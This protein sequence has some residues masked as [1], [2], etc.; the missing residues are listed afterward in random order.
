MKGGVASA[1]QNVRKF[2]QNHFPQCA[3]RLN[4]YGGIGL[5][6]FNGSLRQSLPWKPNSSSICAGVLAIV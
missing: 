1:V 6:H 3:L 2:C 5:A 4:G